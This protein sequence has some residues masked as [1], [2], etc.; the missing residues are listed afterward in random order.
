MIRRLLHVCLK[1]DITLR[2]LA[3]VSRCGLIPFASMDR[4]L[5][6]NIPDFVCRTVKCTC[7][8]MDGDCPMA[9]AG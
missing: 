7:D 1:R 9:I 8:N 5:D 2:S 6:A 4:M 3:A